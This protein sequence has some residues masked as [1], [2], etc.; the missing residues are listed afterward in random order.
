LA[1]IA[2]GNRT[3]VFNLDGVES[4]LMLIS[5]D[6]SV[7]A[8]A[9]AALAAIPT[10]TVQQH[11]EQLAVSE[12]LD[13]AIREAAARYLAAHI[14]HHGL[15]LTAAQVAE[16]ES[17]WR[18][19]QSPEMGTALAAVVGSLKPNAKRVSSRFQRVPAP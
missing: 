18:S 1:S 2:N 10:R 13:P 11:F 8:N 5:T 12:R 7:Y 4:A 16:L 15:L 14:Q 17:A 3:K 9:L 19:A 6:R